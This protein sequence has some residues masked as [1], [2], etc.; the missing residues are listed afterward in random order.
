MTHCAS[1]SQGVSESGD[2]LYLA[3]LN[4]DARQS[5]EVQARIHALVADLSR[6]SELMQEAQA[7]APRE[8]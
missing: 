5:V 8:H 3:L 6:G 7:D 4:K 2:R 1:V